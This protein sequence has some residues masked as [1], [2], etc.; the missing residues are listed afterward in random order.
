M[1]SMPAGG[2]R[3]VR[4][5]ADIVSY[6]ASR[7]VCS[8]QEVVSHVCLD[9]QRLFAATTQGS[10]YACRTDAVSLLWAASL[11]D[12]SIG[13]HPCR[14]PRAQPVGLQHVLEQD[15]LVMPAA[16]PRGHRRPVRPRRVRDALRAPLAPQ[17]AC[18]SSGEVLLLS[19]NDGSLLGC[20][21]DEPGGLL[22]GAWSPEG[23][24]LALVTASGDLVLL[25]SSFEV[26][27]REPA[28]AF[29]PTGLSDRCLAPREPAT[30]TVP[31]AGSDEALAGAAPRACLSWRGDGRYL[32]VNMAGGLD[33]GARRLRCG[34]RAR[35]S[36]LCY[37]HRVQLGSVV[38]CHA[39]CS[40]TIGTPHRLLQGVGAA[41]R[42]PESSFSRRA[43]VGHGAVRG[44]P[45]KRTPRVCRHHRRRRPTRAAARPRRARAARPGCGRPKVNIEAFS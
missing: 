22:G 6:I 35:W 9:A 39:D 3:V 38:A 4:H 7:W 10:V 24:A 26:L 30:G 12:P 41:G 25:S 2:A 13:G 20:V 8:P 28:Q 40:E 1:A 45:A 33:G 14:H 31:V 16:L 37:R 44:I 34:C 11:T 27:S 43:P 5:G 23:D 36:Q 19:A 32:A 42:Q 15:A 29:L 21:H 17:C 18:L